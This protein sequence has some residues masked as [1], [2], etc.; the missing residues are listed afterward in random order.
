MTR[1]GEAG[2]REVAPAKINLTLEIAGR[3]SDGFHEL[4]SL[5]AFAS[6]GDVVAIDL[7]AA[8]GLSVSG[9]F[10][11]QLSGPNILDRALGMLGAV[12][13]GLKLGAVHLEKNLPV[14]A[15][16]GGGSADAGA[17]LRA[18]R[19]VNIARYDVD[20]IGIAQALGADVPVC[21]ESRPL[22]MTGVG[23]QLADLDDAPPVLDAVLVNPLSAVPADK[24]GRVFGALG[25]GALPSSNVPPPAPIFASRKAMLDF[26]R[27]RGNDLSASAKTVVPEIALVLSALNSLPGLEYAALSGA[28]PTCFGIFGTLQEARAAR[29]VLAAAQP[30]WWAVTTRLNEPHRHSRGE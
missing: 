24:T 26:M 11:G 5:V 10:A 23:G 6:V 8:V 13:P 28:G 22:W 29:V 19:R 9:P 1:I 18:V 27:T 17:L 20:W 30:S 4:A 7:T 2:I 3:R 25:A 12:E 15:G 14:A 16:V 21:L